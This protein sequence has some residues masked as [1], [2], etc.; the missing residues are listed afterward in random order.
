VLGFGWF[1]DRFGSKMGYGISIIAWSF[2]AMSH[3]LVSSV[4]GFF[5]VRIALGLGEGGNFPSVIKA[6][7]QWFPKKERALATTLANSGANVGAIAAPAIVIPVALA[8]GWQAPFFMAGIVGLLWLALWIPFFNIPARSKFTTA[9]EVGYIESDPDEAMQDRG[10]AKWSELLR[11]PQA[12][13][14]MVGKFMTDPI[15]YFIL[16]W[17]PDYF[18]STRGLDIKS[19]GPLLITIYAIVT[20]LSIVGGWFTGWLA[21]RGWTVTRARKTGMLLYA[22]LVT[23]I[24]AATFVGNWTAVLLIGLAG[25]AHQAWSANLYT[26]VSDMFPKSTVASLIGM[27]TTAGCIGGILFPIFTGILLDHMSATAG[28]TILFGMCS[29]AYV[30]TFGVHHLLAPKFEQVSLR[31]E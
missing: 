27:G 4:G 23:P 18:K 26:T 16:T 31:T 25:A 8:F 11:H 17:L 3:A 2:A 29:F 22:I 7:A 13:S 12:W 30:I 6:I 19:S 24:L 14:F 1:V 21:S 9:A 5:G 10:R 28:Y 15:W 20:V